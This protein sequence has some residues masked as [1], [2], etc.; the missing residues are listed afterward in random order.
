MY[1]CPKKKVS[2]RTKLNQ[3][4]DDMKK[5]MCW[6]MVVGC[7]AMVALGVTAQNVREKI[8]LDDGWKFAFGGGTPCS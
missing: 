5:M 2:L 3:N 8:L 4:N 7:W 6:V 1:L